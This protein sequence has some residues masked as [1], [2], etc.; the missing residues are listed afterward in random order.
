[1]IFEGLLLAEWYN[2]NS[3]SIAVMPL[4]SIYLRYIK[5]N[6]ILEYKH[7]ILYISIYDSK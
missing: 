2:C 5:I 7:D 3:N 1:M 6:K 4:Y